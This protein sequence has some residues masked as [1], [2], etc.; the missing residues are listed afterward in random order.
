[1]TSGAAIAQ[2]GL[3]YF[4]NYALGLDPTKEDDKVIVD[5]TTDDSG[6]FVFTVKHPVFDGE[7]NIT[8]YEKVTEAAN[9]TTTVTLKYGTSTGALNAETAVT[10]IAPSEMDFSA[11]NVLYY[12]AEVTIGA[13]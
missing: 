6:K 4:S 13:K 5:V 7:G 9:V 11:G 1:M 2:N 3:N 8:G 12:K 10:E